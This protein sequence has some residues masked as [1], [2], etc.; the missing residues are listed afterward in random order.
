[1]KCSALLSLPALLLLLIFGSACI[2]DDPPAVVT[3]FAAEISGILVEVDGCLRITGP[4][5][6]G[7]S[8][9]VWQKDVFRIERRGDTVDIYR[10]GVS[11]GEAPIASWRLGDPLIGGGGVI[12]RPEVVDNHAGVGFSERCEGPYW[13]LGSVQ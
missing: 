3:V 12:R 5:G 9:I 13:L 4:S 8:A 6:T 7:G 2:S 1:M 11:E 10:G